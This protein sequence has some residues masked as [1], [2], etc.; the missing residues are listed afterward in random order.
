MPE[1]SYGTREAE[2]E[3]VMD[4]TGGLWIGEKCNQLI[5]GKAASRGTNNNHGTEANTA[6]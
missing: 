3:A 4:V 2:A 5:R 6:T 1:C